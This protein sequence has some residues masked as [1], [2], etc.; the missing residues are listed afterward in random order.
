MLRGTGDE[1]EFGLI[2]GSESVVG[3]DRT[4]ENANV[5]CRCDEQILAP[6]SSEGEVIR[7]GLRMPAAADAEIA[8]LDVSAE[9]GQAIASDVNCRAWTG[10]KHDIAGRHFRCIDTDRL[11]CIGATA[12]FD[13]LTCSSG[14]VRPVEREARTLARADARIRSGR[15]DEA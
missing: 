5:R 7:P 10:S 14:A 11:A 12:D 2:C 8:E 9:Y 1:D 13:G 4:T 3:T 15:R 6:D